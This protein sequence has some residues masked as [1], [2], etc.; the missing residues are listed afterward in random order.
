MTPILQ[1]LYGATLMVSFWSIFRSLIF[2]LH[3]FQLNGYRLSTQLGWMRK[4]VSRYGVE[5]IVF[6]LSFPG[7]IPQIGL[8][9]FAAAA[10]S[11]A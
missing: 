11:F 4:H 8:M 3:M 5:M 10:L 7:L 2:N 6:A 1:I 9:A